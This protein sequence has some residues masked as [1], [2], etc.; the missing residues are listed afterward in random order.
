VSKNPR[1]SSTDKVG[2]SSRQML[3]AVGFILLAF[4][5]L[6]VF[7]GVSDYDAHRLAKHARIA[8]ATVNRTVPHPAGVEVSVSTGLGI[9]LLFLR[10]DLAVD[11]RG[12]SRR[13]LVYGSGVSQRRQGRNRHRARDEY[14]NKSGR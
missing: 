2:A 10:R 9:V 13:E 12:R 14:H 5:V 7:F 4:S 6:I 11:R 1:R 3:G 8:T